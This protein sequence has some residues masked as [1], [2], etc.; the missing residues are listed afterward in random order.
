VA[1][2]VDVVGLAWRQEQGVE[3]ASAVGE[4]VALGRAAAVRAQALALPVQDAADQPPIIP[5]RRA[6]KLRQ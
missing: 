2:A 4:R 1:R 6:A 3:P 5:A